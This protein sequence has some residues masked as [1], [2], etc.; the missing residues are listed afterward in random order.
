MHTYLIGAEEVRGYARDFLRRLEKFK[1]FPNVWCPVTESGNSLLKAIYNEARQ[2]KYLDKDLLNTIRLLPI[3]VSGDNIEFIKE[4]PEEVIPGNVVL[5]LDGAI[6]S[7]TVMF[8][9]AEKILGHN[10]AELYC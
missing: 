9:S 10:P 1:P 6:H 3:G 5:L 4:K 2:D 7:G 8:R